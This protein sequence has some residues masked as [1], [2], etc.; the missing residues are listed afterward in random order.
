ME[1]YVL[2]DLSFSG[3][4]VLST[5]DHVEQHWSRE[6]NSAGQVGIDLT[7]LNEQGAKIVKEILMARRQGSTIVELPDGTVRCLASS[8]PVADAIYSSVRQHRQQEGHE[9]LYLV[10]KRKVNG[11]QTRCMDAVR[12]VQAA[13]VLDRPMVAAQVERFRVELIRDQDGKLMGLLVLH[14][15]LV[16]GEGGTPAIVEKPID[17][18]KDA[19]IEALRAKLA[20]LEKA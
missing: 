20:E 3:L 18:V 11:D 13:R 14:P 15:N 16:I 6:A 17:P 2:S 12:G 10:D 8:P 19:E 5:V 7:P 9:G 1:R 4:I